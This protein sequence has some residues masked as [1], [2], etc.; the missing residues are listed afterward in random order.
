MWLFNAL[1]YTLHNKIWV[2]I[3]LVFLAIMG[4]KVKYIVINN[5]D[6]VNFVNLK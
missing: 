2:V 1:V 3:D 4:L 5:I 6:T